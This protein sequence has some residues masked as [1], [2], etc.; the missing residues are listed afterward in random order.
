MQ[1]VLGVCML[2]DVTMDKVR[3]GQCSKSGLEDSCTIFYL[4]VQGLDIRK[5][6]K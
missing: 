4:K 6:M 5:G 1:G 3:L 2:C